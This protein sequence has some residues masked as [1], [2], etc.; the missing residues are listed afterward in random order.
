MSEKIPEAYEIDELLDLDEKV[1]WIL[2][3]LVN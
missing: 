1:I 3:W 2:F